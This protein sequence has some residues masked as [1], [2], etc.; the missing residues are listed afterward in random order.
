MSANRTYLTVGSVLL[1]GTVIL[2][3]VS[4]G[5]SGLVLSGTT[6]SAGYSVCVGIG[7]FSLLISLVIGCYGM[8]KSLLWLGCEQWNVRMVARLFVSQIVF[9]CV[10]I[11]LLVISLFAI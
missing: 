6:V 3:G 5:A 10:G 7:L 2:M 8:T 1:S 4:I 9:L 11:L